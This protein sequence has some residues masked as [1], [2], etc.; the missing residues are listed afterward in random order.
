MIRLLKRVISSLTP[1]AS[2]GRIVYD[3][4]DPP[5]PKFID[6]NGLVWPM[7]YTGARDT[8]LLINGNFDYAQR[9]APSVLT[10]YSNTTG[11]VYAG[12]RWGIT[13]ENASVQFRRVDTAGAQQAGLQP[14]FYGEY[15]KLT[16]AGKIITSQVVEAGNCQH[17]RGR[18]DQSRISVP[19]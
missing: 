3:T 5:R 8:N 15:S 13:N 1:A 14:R 19:L 18:S 11:R 4:S 9:Q 16:S 12:D 17:L 2:Q 7:V 10:T 6:E